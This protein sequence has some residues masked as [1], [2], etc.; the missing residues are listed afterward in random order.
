MTPTAPVEQIAQVPPP[1]EP[2]AT[3]LGA[4]ACLGSLY[5]RQRR[6]LL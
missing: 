1:A 5:A 6:T 4:P 3:V 2:S